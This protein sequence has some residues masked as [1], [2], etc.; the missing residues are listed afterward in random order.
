MDSHDQEL[1]DKQLRSIYQPPRQP[2]I[3]ILGI[4]AVFLGGMIAGGLLSAETI[5]P[6]ANA[7]GPAL[8]F[9]DAGA[10]VTRN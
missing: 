9:L 3:I 2:G 5:K 8:A 6:I 4:L 1:L 7:N 10:P